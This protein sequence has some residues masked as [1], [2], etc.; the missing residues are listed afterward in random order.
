MW[1][2]LYV[3]DHHTIED[4]GISMGK[5]F[6]DAINA[7]NDL[8]LVKPIKDFVKGGKYIIGICLGM[9]VLYEKSFEYG[10]LGLIEG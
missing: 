1:W 9:Q 5:A 2:D 10:G 3:D 8:E 6:K 4:L 7:L